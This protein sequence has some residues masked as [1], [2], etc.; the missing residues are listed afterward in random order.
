MQIAQVLAG[1]SLGE[2]DLL[3]RA[4]G[5]KI[6]SEM[7]AQR[8][9][10]V[11]KSVKNGVDK[12]EA[13]GIFDLI[14]KFAEYGFNKSH[15][16]AYALI[17]YQTAYIKANHTVEFFAATM[18][19]EM[20][21]TDKLG[22]LREEALHDG[23]S[24][25]PPDINRSGAHFDVEENHIRYALAAVRNVGEQAM[26]QVVSE[27]RKHGPYRD[28]FDLIAR[29]P[30]TALS[31][32]NLEFLIKAGAFDAM[33]PSR[34]QLLEHLD[35]IMAYGTLAEQEKQST[36]VSLFASAG[37]PS[38]PPTM[39][40]VPEWTTLETLA[41]EFEAIGFY[42]S[43]HPL[44]GYRP[45]LARKGIKPYAALAEALTPQYTSVTLCGIVTGRKF[46]ASERGRFAFVQM[47]DETGVF[48]AS[49]FDEKLLTTKRDLLE[50]GTLLL[51][52]ADAKQD[53]SGTRLIV[54]TLENLETELAKSSRSTLLKIELARAEGLQQLK[55]FLSSATD[56]GMA[57]EIT[58]TVAAGAQATMRLPGRYLLTPQTVEKIRLLDA[59]HTVEEA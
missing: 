45:A 27:R 40:P 49:V 58:T 5:K 57:V 32:R 28:V 6:R 46:K 48:E 4:M 18:A 56:K 37:Q 44:T 20:H 3:R 22:L 53:E 9:V 7:E 55:P 30:P 17:A 19:Y 25:L 14:A 8:N 15:A 24:L 52:E 42:L 54:R 12:R 47:S 1:Y 41:V 26:E 59:V 39:K 13:A 35:S 2:A 29:V 34:A 36:Q 31:K 21:N 43:A 51:M 38:A 16:A 33:H 50:P 10:F 11:A 23:I